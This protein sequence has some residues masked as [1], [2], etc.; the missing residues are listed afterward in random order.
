MHLDSLGSFSKEQLVA[1]TAFATDKIDL[2][3]QR[4]VGS[5]LLLSAV[6]NCTE[7]AAASGA[8]TVTFQVVQSDSPTLSGFEVLAQ[9]GAIPKADLVAGKFMLQVPVPQNYSLATPKGKRY[10]GIR[11]EVNGGPLTSGRFTAQLIQG[12]VPGSHIHYPAAFIAA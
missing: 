12:G 3:E 11:Y 7:S 10:L 9:S 1:S 4:D 6:F 2:S 8:A 5:G